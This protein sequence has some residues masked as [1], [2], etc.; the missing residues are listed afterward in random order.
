M[1][2]QSFRVKDTRENQGW[3]GGKTQQNKITYHSKEKGEKGRKL[4]QGSEKEGFVTKGRRKSGWTPKKKE[5]LL[6][7]LA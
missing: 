5:R 1:S 3:G 2:S 4:T 6:A 7:V